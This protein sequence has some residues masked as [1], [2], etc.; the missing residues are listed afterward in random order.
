MLYSCERRT[1]E[2]LSHNLI[3]LPP[4]IYVKKAKETYWFY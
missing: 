4:K 2:T 1:D 3:E